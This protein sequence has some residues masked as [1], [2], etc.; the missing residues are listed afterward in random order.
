MVLAG[1]AAAGGQFCITAAYRL[2]PA[3]E[4]AVFDYAQVLFAAVLGF[5]FLN[6]IPK[7]LSIVGYVVIIGAAVGNCIYRLEKSK[8][9]ARKQELLQKNNLESG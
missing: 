8:R 1:L 6:Q 2:A 3:K 4:I 9:E 5:A 7:L